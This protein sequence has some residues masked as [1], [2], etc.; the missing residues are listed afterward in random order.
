[1]HVAGVFVSPLT[2]SPRI[3]QP[4][5]REPYPHPASPAHL[6]NGLPIRPA[7]CR[8]LVRFDGMEPSAKARR[9]ERNRLP[10]QR[11]MRHR[12]AQ[13]AGVLPAIDLA[14]NRAV[15]GQTQP[16]RARRKVGHQA[17]RTVCLGHQFH[18]ICE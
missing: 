18:A 5:R 3:A 11:Q 12:D 6:H 14:G 2:G 9:V 15:A 16:V 8:C 4:L 17:I 10:V 1:M 13:L 7:P